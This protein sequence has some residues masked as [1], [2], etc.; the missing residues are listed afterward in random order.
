[1]NQLQLNLIGIS[2]PLV[3]HHNQ[4]MQYF[5]SYFTDS[6]ASLD[7]SSLFLEIPMGFIF[8]L[9]FLLMIT[10]V[11]FVRSHM[12]K[13]KAQ[14]ELDKHKIYIDELTSIHKEEIHDIK[15]NAQ[16]EIDKHKLSIE[17][18][19]ICDNKY[20]ELSRNMMDGYV[21]IDMNGKIIEYNMAFEEML[22]Y[23]D[24]QMQDLT[25]TDLT[26]PNWQEI[27]S[28]IV[29][30]EV[31]KDGFSSL[32][33]KEYV[34][35]DGSLLPVELRTYL[36]KDASGHP[37][38]MWANVRDI[39]RRKETERKLVDTEHMLQQALDCSHLGLWDWN[40]KTGEEHFNKEWAQMI[41]YSPDEIEPNIT[42]WERVVDPEAT[43]GVR[44]S[45]QE[46]F[47][48]KTPLYETQY[49]VKSKFGNWVW[50]LDRGK[51]IERDSDGKP[52][53]MIGTHMDITYYKQLE[54]DQEE[55]RKQLEDLRTH[56]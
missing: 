42:S 45:I 33:E 31:L 56:K 25:Y 3:Y 9:I 19:K 4:V 26:P 34:K 23:D 55:L 2:D 30:D 37:D 35:K 50:I 11:V 16:D 48:G 22:G 6:F 8:L 40:I 14:R 53:R 5:K 44:R 12:A 15:K 51:V 47:N 13:I 21:C 10:T 41:G 18:L 24:K 7:G 28:K 43:E 1:M 27:E 36:L 52:L 54:H 39:S 20:R 17:H 49:R 29:R 32:Y 38:G 46:H